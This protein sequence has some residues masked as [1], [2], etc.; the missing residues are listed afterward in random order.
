MGFFPI[1]YGQFDVALDTVGN[2]ER[3]QI[4][5]VFDV[6]GFAGLGALEAQFEMDCG[7]V[8]NLDSLFVAV[9]GNVAPS[10]Y[11]AQIGV[12]PAYPCTNA[13]QKVKARSACSLNRV[14]Q[15][16]SQG[17]GD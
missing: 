11:L 12:I 8:D 6:A 9:E 2:I 3:Q 15:V 7:A 16:I 17:A 14:V 1:Y 10:P 5:G 13:V 4:A